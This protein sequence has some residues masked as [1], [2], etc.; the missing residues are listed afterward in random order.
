MPLTLHAATAADIATPLFAGRLVAAVA[1]GGARSAALH[2]VIAAV[3]AI[4]VLGLFMLVAR[5]ISYW[6]IVRFTLRMM[7]DVE[8]EAFDRVQALSTAWHAAS[9]SGA[10]VRQITRGAHAFDAGEHH[11]AHEPRFDSPAFTA[12]IFC[13]VAWLKPQPPV[14]ANLLAVPRPT[15][16]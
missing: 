2:A 9:F 5:Q 7:Q 4:A 8:A 12:L 1:G 3:G 6:A 15:G 16:T 13:K 10:T 11:A 14:R